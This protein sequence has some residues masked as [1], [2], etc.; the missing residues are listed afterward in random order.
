[1]TYYI[2]RSGNYF[3]TDQAAMQ[4]EQRLPAGN[5]SIGITSNGDWFLEPVGLFERPPKFYGDLTKNAARIMTTFNDRDAST[6][7]LLA[8]EKGSG[9]SQLARELAMR[10]YEQSIP[11]LIIGAPYCG[12]KFNDFIQSIDQPACVLFDEFEKVYNSEQQQAMLTLLDG[13]YPTKKLFVLTCNSFYRIDTHM[14]NRPGRLFYS[15]EFKGLTEAD[16]RDYCDDKLKNK[17]HLESVVKFTYLFTA[18]NF[19]MLKALVEE[20][21]RFDEPA[22]QAYLMLNARPTPEES[23]VTYDVKLFAPNNEQLPV[24]Q[25]KTMR[26]KGAPIDADDS[27]ATLDITFGKPLSRSEQVKQ[28]VAQHRA[29]RAAQKAMEKAMAGDESAD[30]AIDEMFSEQE[31]PL[32]QIEFVASDYY[33][34]SSIRGTY[35]YRNKDGFTAVLIPRA[36]NEHRWGDY[37]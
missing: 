21:N 5:Y 17:D 15:L 16:I 24:H 10:C 29:R 7:V 23:T 14:R 2:R 35:A 32:K 37:F 3:P 12:E 33:A 19:D 9:K 26:V 8:G 31:G 36:K 13:M 6:G 11:T 4:I 30:E 18:F 34:P 22:N 27:Y 25:P 1:M 28:E 20:M